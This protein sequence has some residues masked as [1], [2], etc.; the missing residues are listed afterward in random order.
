MAFARCDKGE[1]KRDAGAREITYLLCILNVQWSGSRN[2]LKILL[3]ASI[4]L[5]PLWISR[6]L[7]T[8]ALL[9]DFQ[10]Q[11]FTCIKMLL[12]LCIVYT[13]LVSLGGH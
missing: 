10:K 7:T 11:L 12:R 6:G 13:Q 1:G 8:K 3:P 5:I 2:L 9:F 4:K